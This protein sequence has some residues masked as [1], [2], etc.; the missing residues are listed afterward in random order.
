MLIVVGSF[1]DFVVV[2]RG[3]VGEGF[4]VVVVVRA[5][6][7]AGCWDV[8]VVFAVVFA[9]Y[10][11]KLP[12]ENE[13][14][15]ITGTVFVGF[16]VGFRVGVVERCVDGVLVVVLLGVVFVTVVVGVVG[17]FV[18]LV[19]Y[20]WVVEGRPGADVGFRVAAQS[21][22]YLSDRPLSQYNG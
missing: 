6:V 20:L 5:L 12:L 19:E 13:N 21:I 10:Q 9:G 1:G 16:G 2:V 8:E 15:D 22:T 17:G 7:V 3:F 14:D 4:R 11:L 18:P